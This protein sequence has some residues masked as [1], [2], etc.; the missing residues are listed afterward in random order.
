MAAHQ[1][2]TTFTP[3]PTCT[4]DIYTT[5]IYYSIGGLEPSQCFPSGWA[6]TSQYYSPG[7][8]PAGYTEACS[9][10][11]SAGTVTETQATCCPTYVYLSDP[12]DFFSPIQLPSR[13]QE[14]MYRVARLIISQWICVLPSHNIQLSRPSL[15]LPNSR[16]I[17][18]NCHGRLSH[19]APPRNPPPSH[20]SG[21]R[22]R[23][24]DP[25]PEH[26]LCL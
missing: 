24:L 5:S 8:C 17:N 25:I 23:C 18:H 15:C 26:R 7:L 21:E 2:T 13:G 14:S 1:L 20:G 9:S 19:D 22:L 16:P 4:A 3:A 12:Y 10:L 11:V 6:S